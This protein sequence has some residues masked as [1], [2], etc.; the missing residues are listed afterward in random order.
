MVNLNFGKKHK[1]SLILGVLIIILDFSVF[2][3]KP[4]FVPVL[5]IAVTFAWIPY[6]LDM[7]RENKRQ[8]ELNQAYNYGLVFCIDLNPFTK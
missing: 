3:G 1:F 7:L 2:K 8:K 4:F 5:A 6:W